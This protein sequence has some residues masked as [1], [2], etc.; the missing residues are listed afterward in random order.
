MALIVIVPSRISYKQRL[1]WHW[2][3]CGEVPYE[4][5]AIAHPV[6]VLGVRALLVK[7]GTLVDVAI[8]ADEKAG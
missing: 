3:P 6:D 1:P 2:G 5:R 7:A 4:G 8:V